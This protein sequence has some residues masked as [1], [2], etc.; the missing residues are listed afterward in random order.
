MSS[1]LLD[2]GDEP[3]VLVAEDVAGSAISTDEADL[4]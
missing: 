1:G 4:T 2:D 3:P